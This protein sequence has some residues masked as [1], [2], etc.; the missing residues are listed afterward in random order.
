MWKDGG[1]EHCSSAGW[2]ASS[3]SHL[4][5]L[6]NFRVSPGWPLP[7]AQ[8]CQDRSGFSQPLLCVIIDQL[9]FTGHIARTAWSCRF[10]LYNTG[11]IRP[12]FL[13][14]ATQLV[15]QALV[16]SRL[17]Y[18]LLATCIKVKALMFAYR[19]I[20]GSAP[21]YLNSLLQTY[22]PFRSLSSERHLVLPS[23]RG[24]KSLSQTFTW[25]V[26]CWENNLTN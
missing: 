7:S 18:A 17:E 11:K 22:K 19:T 3:C 21:Q 16:Q 15:I 13:E 20:A 8:P 1:D 26:A 14:H 6:G 4:S 12:F 10:V 24:T 25:T 23:Q 2:S 5:L 9:N